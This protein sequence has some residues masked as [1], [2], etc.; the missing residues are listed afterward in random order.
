MRT[1]TSTP[2]RATRV[3]RREPIILPSSRYTCCIRYTR[4][5]YRVVSLDTVTLVTASRSCVTAAWLTAN[6]QIARPTGAG[7]LVD[8]QLTLLVAWLRLSY[9]SPPTNTSRRHLWRCSHLPMIRE[10]SSTY[11]ILLHAYAASGRL[12]T[13]QIVDISSNKPPS[14]GD[15]QRAPA[16][17]KLRAGAVIHSES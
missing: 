15:N 5:L 6:W 3:C 17:A 13:R 1:N 8:P 14:W 9:R 16:S 10:R 4:L 11:S 7:G 12:K 2:R